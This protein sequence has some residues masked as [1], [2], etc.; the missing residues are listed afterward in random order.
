M[1]LTRTPVP[2]S[3][4]EMVWARDTT[5]ALE[6]EYGVLPALERSPATEAVPMMEPPAWGLS[7]DVICMAGEANLAAA[8][9]LDGA[10][11]AK[12]GKPGRWV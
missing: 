4:Y 8:K 12:W 5:A 10:L 7:E 11:L 9:T 1:A 2:V 6:A 3:W